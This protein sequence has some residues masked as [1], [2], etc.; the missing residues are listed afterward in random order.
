MLP[1]SECLAVAADDLDE[2]HDYLPVGL[3]RRG[4]DIL[5]GTVVSPAYGTELDARHAGP[6]EVDDVAGT[7]AAHA[8]GVAAEVACRDLAEHLDVRVPASHV[9]RFAVEEDFDVCWQVHRAYL[10]ND[11]FGVL[12]GEEADVE[13][14]R[15]AVRHAVEHVAPDDTGEVHAR[16]RKELGPFRGERQVGDLAVVLVGEERGVLAQPGLRAVGALTPQRHTDVEH[17]LGLGADMEVRRLARDQEVP[18]VAVGDQDL[19]ARFRTVLTLFI[20][21]DEELDRGFGPELL[22][23]L[24]GVHHGGEGAFHVVDAT[25]V[26][27]ITLLARLELRLLARHHVD[28]AVQ[29]YPWI[30]SPNPHH[31]R[32]KVAAGSSA[33][34]ARRLESPRPEPAIDKVHRRLRRARCVR[35]VAHELAGKRMDLGVL[36]YYRQRILRSSDVDESDVFYKLCEHFSTLPLAACQHA[37]A[38]PSGRSWPPP[39]RRRSRRGR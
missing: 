39:R 14:V 27:L 26:E 2:L 32:G 21:D 17:T 28:V 31:E 37:Q 8:D 24:D 30:S 3:Q 35:P 25:T 38:D 16:V 4:H 12:V 5:V 22:Q 33:R 19:S 15:T 10:T 36:G 29:E 1:A 13:V 18:D 34:I 7:V 9:G 20:G 11:L 23:V 6:L